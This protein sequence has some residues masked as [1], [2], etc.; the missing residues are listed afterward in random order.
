MKSENI[1][2]II[3]NSGHNMI[4][5]YYGIDQNP[6]PGEEFIDMM[7]IKN[8]LL[9][10]PS[11]PN[12]ITFSPL[13]FLSDEEVTQI[14]A[15]SVLCILNPREEIISKYKEILQKINAQKAGIII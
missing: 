3:L 9:A 13:S 14:S 6:D 15:H 8:P 7:Q 12:S 11:G 5:E 2:L 1:K 10:L 4:C